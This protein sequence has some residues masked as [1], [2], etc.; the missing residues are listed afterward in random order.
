MVTS[1]RLGRSPLLP[2]ELFDTLVKGSGRAG[3]LDG[4]AARDDSFA[5]AMLVET[6]DAVDIARV[7]PEVLA[8]STSP[9]STSFGFGVEPSR[10]LST[11]QSLRTREAQ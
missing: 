8:S 4:V 6:V 11:C 9:S 5:A 3:M 1:G 2:L 10:E 7:F